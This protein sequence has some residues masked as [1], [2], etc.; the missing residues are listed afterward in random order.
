MKLGAGLVRPLFQAIGEPLRTQLSR[1]E[2]QISLRG[3]GFER[4]SDEGDEEWS[5]RFLGKK[6]L[7]SMSERLVH[8]QKIA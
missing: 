7:L 8:A 2:M 4:V 1:E 5:E 6:A 3:Y